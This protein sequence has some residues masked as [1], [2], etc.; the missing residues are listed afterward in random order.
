MFSDWLAFFWEQIEQINTVQPGVF[1][2]PWLF[3]S[4]QPLRLIGKYPALIL[5]QLVSLYVI[6]RIGQELKLSKVRMV[7]VFLSAPVFW[8]FFMGQI[9]GL[10]LSAYLRGINRAF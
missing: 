4:L 5:V 6:F 2:I 3:V 8:N 10:M 9:D 7:M 1:N